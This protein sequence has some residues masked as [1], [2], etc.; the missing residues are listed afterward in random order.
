MAY[1][2]YLRF[3]QLF[4]NYYYFLLD[5]FSKCFNAFTIVSLLFLFLLYCVVL[6]CFLF[7]E[8]ILFQFCS[9]RIRFS[10][11]LHESRSLCFNTSIFVIGIFS[12]SIYNSEFVYCFIIGVG[13]WRPIFSD[14][15][16]TMQDIHISGKYF[17]IL[18]I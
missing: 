8:L 16:M 1:L 15:F 4:F 17:C 5:E 3:L 10:H 18:G 13:W 11:V 14:G 12:Y 6:L 2:L 9:V 7:I